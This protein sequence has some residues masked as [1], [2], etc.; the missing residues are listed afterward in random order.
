MST[1]SDTDTDAET[2]IADDEIGRAPEYYAKPVERFELDV[3]DTNDIDF[4]DDAR[5]RLRSVFRKTVK[6]RGAELIEYEA[7]EASVSIGIINT[8][9]V[10]LPR[11]MRVIQRQTQRRYGSQLER[12]KRRSHRARD[13][14]PLKWGGRTYLG[15]GDEDYTEEPPEIPAADDLD[16]LPDS[17]IR[18]LAMAHG[19]RDNLAPS[20]IKDELRERRPD[21][22]DSFGS[23]VKSKLTGSE[24]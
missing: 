19:L 6:R 21:E 16:H 4:D 12:A 10:S 22:P 20:R 9:N 7:N 17:E 13:A 2:D 15:R 14:E 11:L 23:R 8:S 3:S 18:R 1:E 24:S 5:T